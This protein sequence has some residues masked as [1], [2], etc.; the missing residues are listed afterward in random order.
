MIGTIAFTA[1]APSRAI[2]PDPEATAA[3]GRFG[4]LSSPGV[5]SL[6]L[7]SLPAG[8]G[9]GICEVTL[10]AF[11]EASGSRELAGVLL[12][13]WSLGSAA[14]GL[15]FGAW[16]RRPPLQRV[17]LAVTAL[18]P[19]ALLPLAAAS[20]IPVMAL[21]VL[22][23]GMFIAPLLAT[24]NELIGWVAPPGARTE[25]YTWP[26]TAFV[27]GIAIGSA[28]AGAIVESSSW[29]VAFLV[30]A[31]AAAVGAVVAVARRATLNPQ[32]GADSRPPGDPYPWM[33]AAVCLHAP[34]SRLVHACLRGADGGPGAGLAGDRHRRARADLGAHRLGQDARRV[35]VGARPPRGRADR[36]R[37]AHAPR[38]RLAAEG[39]LL[40][41]REEPARAA[42][43]HR[44][45]HHRRH[46]HR[47]HAAEG[48]RG[49]WSATRPTSSS[50]RPSR[51][52]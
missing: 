37:R 7:T 51:C 32:V 2:L 4:A 25:A 23:A 1:Q 35:P 3:A 45:R 11:S 29:R 6:V 46:P 5:R 28:M 27:G 9:I 30:A 26:V 15:A 42:A 24:R 47:R 52:T 8:I 38:L 41:H 50:R 31:G 13:V 39:A 20:S 44:R 43:R 34:G 33:Y 12:A 22:P 48:A 14:G 10:P 21:L 17:H 49:T 18:L 36:R 16:T 19:L 40:R